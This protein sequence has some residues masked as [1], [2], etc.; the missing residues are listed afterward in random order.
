MNNVLIQNNQEPVNCGDS[1][2]I[3]KYIR[4]RDIRDWIFNVINIIYCLHCF[5]LTHLNSLIAYLIFVDFDHN[6]SI[7]L[8]LR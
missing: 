6:F 8:L 3:D 2:I 5:F 7:F 1:L 4:L